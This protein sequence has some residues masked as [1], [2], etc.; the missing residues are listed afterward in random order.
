ML[1]FAC[2]IGLMVRLQRRIAV[3]FLLWPFACSL[4]DCVPVGLSGIIGGLRGLIRRRS[5]I[6]LIL[7]IGGC[8]SEDCWLMGVRFG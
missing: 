7:L 8:L 4:Q 2:V 6:I 5:A 3:A 1:A